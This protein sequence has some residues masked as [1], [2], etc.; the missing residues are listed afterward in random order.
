MAHSLNPKVYVLTFT[1]FVML[2][3]EFIVAGLLPEI[4]SALQITVGDAGWLV[5]AFALGMGVGAPLIAAFTHKVS[6]RLLLI[7][8]CVALFL[9]NTICALTDNFALL[10]IGRALGGVGVAMFWTNAALAAAAM[11]KA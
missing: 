2:S 3:S 1:T 11:C 9:G 8:A 10:M 7:K 4:A 5:T 6:L